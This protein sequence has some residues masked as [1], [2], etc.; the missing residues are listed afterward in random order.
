MVRRFLYFPSLFLVAGEVF[1]ANPQRGS[2]LYQA[3]VQCHGEFA[4]GLPA[5]KTPK[6]AGQ[7]DWYLAS[8]LRAFQA[9]KERKS[10]AMFPALSGLSDQD[11]ED[12]AAYIS[13]LPPL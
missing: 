7:F 11:I 5:M 10:P 3:C 1:S 8:S 6:M 4:E 9:R 13:G 12:L 2:S